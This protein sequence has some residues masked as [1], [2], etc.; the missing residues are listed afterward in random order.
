MDGNLIVIYKT[1]QKTAEHGLLPALTLWGVAGA[2]QGII[3]SGN[4]AIE[5]PLG[6][7]TQSRGR[8]AVD[9]ATHAWSIVDKT[10]IIDGILYRNLDGGMTRVDL[11]NVPQL[12][13]AR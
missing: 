12:D 13:I 4:R 10:R 8:M 3:R 5:T 11:E 1:I 9:G 7:A 2:A 6:R